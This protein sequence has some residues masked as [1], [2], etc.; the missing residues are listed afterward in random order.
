MSNPNY[1]AGV[2][3]SDIDQIGEPLDGGIET[4]DHKCPSCGELMV[5]TG[6]QGYHCFKGCE[7]EAICHKCN[8]NG[9]TSEHD[10]GVYSH[11]GEGNCLGC[12]PV[13]V[14][15]LDCDGKGHL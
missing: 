12:C 13:Q 1:P 10:E 11:D 15:C 4:V 3:H 5:D 7:G 2:T 8:G 14:L 6:G 9:W